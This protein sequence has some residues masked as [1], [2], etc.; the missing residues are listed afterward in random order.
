MDRIAQMGN[1]IAPSTD[2][3]NWETLRKVLLEVVVGLAGR[4]RLK[5]P[6]TRR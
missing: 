4:L 3:H 1:V 5:F 6:P 2:S